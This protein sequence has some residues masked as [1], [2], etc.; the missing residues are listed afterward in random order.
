MATGAPASADAGRAVEAAIAALKTENPASA[1]PLVERALRSAPGDARLWHLKG[2]MHRAD[3]QREHAIPALR[4]AAT[5]APGHALIAHG[6]A[7]TLLEA[8]LPSVDAF[9]QAMR[10]AP[11]DPQLF[12]GMVAA[13]VAE[14]RS[15]D[16]AAGLERALA[17][18]PQWADGHAMLSDLRWM[19]GEREGFARSFDDALQL[20]PTDIALRAAQLNTLLHAEQYEAILER[21]PAGRKISGDLPVFTYNE[22]AAYAERGDMALADALFGKLGDSPDSAVQLRRVRHLLR[23]GRVDQAVAL[24]DAWLPTPHGEGFWPYASV[25]WRISGDPRSDWLQGDPDLVGIY[26]LRDGNASFD[27]LAERLRA[28]HTTRGQPLVQSVRGGTQTDGNLFQ[29][30]D[31]VIVELRELVRRTTAEHASRLPPADPRHPT[32]GP[33][34]SPIRFS[35]SWSVRLQAGG[36]HANHVHPMGWFSSALYISLP[37]D[38]GHDQAGWLTLGDPASRAMPLDVGPLRMVEPKPGR[39]VLFPSW[40]WHGTRPFGE[41]ERMTVAFDVAV[42][43]RGFPA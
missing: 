43:N 4:R 28:L 18:S 37:P 15:E 2:L 19:A 8:G 41:G 22:A 30:I 33:A 24:I 42:P 27:Q 16:A 12:K 13:L 5:L 11:G 40:M 14:G 38:L 20:F 6:L 35:G 9:A 1:L 10:L 29:R 36:F 26:D 17:A 39:L 7:S 31:P 32:L 21:A 23:A 34:R 3:E 25:A